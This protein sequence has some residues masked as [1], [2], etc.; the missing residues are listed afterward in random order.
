M[1]VE[2]R[3]SVVL[4]AQLSKFSG[5]IAKSVKKP[6]RRLIKEMLYGSQASKDVKLS[7]ISRTLKEEQ[8]LIKT[9]DRLSRN[10]DD[11]DFTEAINEE[12]MRLG[13]RKVTKEM[14]IAIDPGD[15]RKKYAKKMEFLGKVRDG[16]EHEIGDGYWL[17]KAVATDIESR[18]VIPL[19]CE[20]YS[21][22]AEGV[23]SENS[24]ILKLIDVMFRHLQ[25]RG[26]HA[27]DRGGDRGVLYKKY[28][29]ETKP[30]RFVIRLVNRTLIHHGKGRNCC[31]LAKVLP[32]P[33]KT[34]LI[35][36]EEGKE[37]KKTVHYNAVPVKLPSYAHKLY[38]VVVK[39]F[40]EE[41]MML[42][43]S[44]E[45]EKNRK[46]S[47]WRIV[48]YYLARWKCDESYRYI[49]QCYNLEDVRVQSYI[50]IRNI[51]VLVLAVSYFASVYLGQ[52]IKLKML[53]ERI[54]ILSKRFFGVPSFF[55]YAIAD[56]IFNL[57][58][59]DKTALRGIKQNSL[60]DFQLCFDFG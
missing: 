54:F 35:I 22:L 60:E 13:A 32:T 28:L 9:E 12:M 29:A 25:D 18:Q 42:L 16:S 38:L 7:N 47:I 37:R 20:A 48:E 2:Y 36:Y 21:L 44:C 56:G 17:C 10:L 57:L 30:K 33:Y 52:N 3:T 46:E 41:P 6:K 55:N 49:K 19:Y 11:E 26:I 40:G 58:Y 23:K 4:K 53:V 43:T 27:I 8:E 39:G 50:S 34:A 59:P 31:E 5:I 45:M 1:D 15:L 24:Q 51:V 14:V